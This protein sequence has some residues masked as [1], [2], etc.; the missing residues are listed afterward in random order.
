MVSDKTFKLVEGTPKEYTKIADSGNPI[1]SHFCGDCGSTLWR[2]GPSFPG[3]KV[4]KIGVVDDIEV[5]HSV[6][7]AVELFPH[8]RASWQPKMEGTVQM[9]DMMAETI[10]KARES[11]TSRV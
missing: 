7:P 3:E 2:D 5:L 6:T 8:E 1:T 10:K 11:V 4:I 9:P